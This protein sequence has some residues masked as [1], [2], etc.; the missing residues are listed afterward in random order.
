MR[1]MYGLMANAKR[2][3]WPRVRLNSA[4]QADLQWWR[5]FLVAWNGSSII[6]KARS[7]APDIRVWSDASGKWGCGALWGCS[8]FQATWGKTSMTPAMGH[9]SQRS[10]PHNPG[11]SNLGK[12]WSHSIV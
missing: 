1:N 3:G 5:A 2:G 9:C 6:L 12:T 7:Q 4:F 10:T 11:G 8:W